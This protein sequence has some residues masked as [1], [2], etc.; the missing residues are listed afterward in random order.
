MVTSSASFGGSQTRVGSG[1]VTEE[2]FPPLITS[3]TLAVNK[4]NQ[5]FDGD[6]KL[7][8]ILYKNVARRFDTAQADIS[9]DDKEEVTTAWSA[10]NPVVQP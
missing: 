5:M 9:V 1:D 3:Q 7:T 2:T 4:V 6:Q 8:N 10:Q